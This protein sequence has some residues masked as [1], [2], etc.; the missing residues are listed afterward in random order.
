MFEVNEEGDLYRMQ[1]NNGVLKGIPYMLEDKTW[2]KS[3]WAGLE[4]YFEEY[5]ELILQEVARNALTFGKD[6]PSH[7]SEPKDLKLKSYHGYRD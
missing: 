1:F 4:T 7:S 2:F 3:E 5:E 6:T